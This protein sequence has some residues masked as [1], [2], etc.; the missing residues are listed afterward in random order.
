MTAQVTDQPETMFEVINERLLS[1][2]SNMM[3]SLRGLEHL[4]TSTH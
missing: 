1:L 3:K 2:A 4:A